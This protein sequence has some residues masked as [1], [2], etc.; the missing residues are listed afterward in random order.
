MR[1]QFTRTGG[2][3]GIRMGGTIDTST[4]DPGEAQ[5]LQQELENAHFFELPA[6]LSGGTG[7]PERD[8]FQYEITVEDGGQ[9]HTVVAGES[10]IPA[11][12]QPLIQHLQQLVRTSRG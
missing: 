1:I 10:A 12:L 7:S 9:K 5:T 2:F 8:R 3:A 4:L 11:N 6:Q